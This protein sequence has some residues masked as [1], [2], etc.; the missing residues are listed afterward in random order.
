MTDVMG[1]TSRERRDISGDTFT[2]RPVIMGR[3]GVVTTGHYL[4]SAAGLRMYARGG[5]AVDAAV[6]AGLALAVLK[7]Q[8]NGIGG[9]APMLVHDPRSGRVVAISGQG[10]APALATSA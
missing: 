1:T 7:P 8:D 4:A 10:T 2:T 5:N 6:A 9:E 3:R